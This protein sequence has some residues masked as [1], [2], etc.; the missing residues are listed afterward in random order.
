[1][2]LCHTVLLSRHAPSDITS[3]VASAPLSREWVVTG[4]QEL[5]ACRVRFCT[6][7]LCE[8]GSSRGM[9]PPPPQAP[10]HLLPTPCRSRAPGAAL[11]AHAAAPPHIS[12]LP[13]R[14]CTQMIG[15]QQPTF[16]TQPDTCASTQTQDIAC[17]DRLETSPTNVSLPT[18]GTAGVT[19][20]WPFVTYN[21][22]GLGQGR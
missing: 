21:V 16:L 3:C 22:L 18:H 11:H 20:S 15:I 8:E 4:A 6:V 19:G 17:D 13:S 5:P 1:M 12:L 9:L 10:A 2:V 7:R 14:W